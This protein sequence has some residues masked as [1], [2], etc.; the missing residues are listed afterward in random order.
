MRVTARNM[1]LWCLVAAL[2]SVSGF[3]A[4]VRD[5]SLVEAVKNQNANAA[6]A[7]ISSM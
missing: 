3:A 6:A 5:S 1:T 4:S 7:L 2:A